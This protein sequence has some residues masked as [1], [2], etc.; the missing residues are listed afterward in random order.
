MRAIVRDAA[1]GASFAARGAEIAVASLSDVGALTAALTGVRGAYLLLPPDLSAETPLES[2]ERL[3][4]AIAQAVKASRVPHVVLLSSIAAQ[5]PAG[6]GPIR[7]VHVAERELR[8]TG[9]AVTAVRAASFHENWGAGLGMLGQGILPAFVPP[10]HAYAQ[11]ATK[12]VG[13]VVA[14]ALVEGGQGF[15][16][17]ELAGPREYAAEDVAAAL[18][19][20]TGKAIAV[21]QAPLE[22]VVPTYT[23]FG[24]SAPVAALFREM[25]AG[26]ASGHI[27]W[28]GGT[29]R[30]VR[31]TVEIEDTLRSLLG[32]TGA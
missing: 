13:R 12:D 11:V 26:L 7:A 1:K 10:K 28:E 14:S 18:S 32:A 29:A 21:Q 27:A 16:A 8:A 4:I 24:I 22:A 15:Q 19:K 31:G 9:A 3:A 5:H 20:L 30:F 23:S 6:T 17:I 25:Y 2:M